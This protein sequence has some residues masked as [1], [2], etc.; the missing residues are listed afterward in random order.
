MEALGLLLVLLG[1]LL[2][3]LTYTESTGQVLKVLF[4]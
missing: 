4:S 3:F 1:V 2:I